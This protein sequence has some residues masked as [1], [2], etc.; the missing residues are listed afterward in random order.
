MLLNVVLWLTVTHTFKGNGPKLADWSKLI[1]MT[2]RSCFGTLLAPKW[3]LSTG[4]SLYSFIN[5]A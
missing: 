4:R 3:E 5:F 1:G 2:L